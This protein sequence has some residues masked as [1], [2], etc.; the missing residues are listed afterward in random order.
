M[1]FCQSCPKKSSCKQICKKLESYLCHCQAKN[2]YS[3]RHY[4]RKT[5]LWDGA[6]IEKLAIKRAF[7][8]RF[9]K[10]YRLSPN[11]MQ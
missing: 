2:G 3:D 1:P 11:P 9:G 8:I 10:R 6:E 4:R 7:E 5:L